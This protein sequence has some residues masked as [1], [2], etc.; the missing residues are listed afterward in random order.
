[1]NQIRKRADAEI[2]RLDEVWDRF[3]NL[4]VQDLEG[5]EILYREMR[6]RFGMYFQGGMGAAALQTRLE[7]FDLEAE[8]ESLREIIRT[9]KGQKKTRALKRLKVVSAFLNTRNSPDGHG[10]RLRPGHP[11]GP[12]PDGAARRWPVRDLATSTTCTAGSST[13]TTASS[14]C[15][16]SARP[17]S[18]ST[19]RSGCCRRPS[20]RCSTTAAAAV[21]SPV[22][23]TAR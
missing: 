23:A 3:R 16:T 9:G 21:R 17:R 4:K 1:M 2:E 7:S 22:R 5:D 20:T 14:G 15:S 18:S 8:A 12:A 11:A 13:A 19:T 10:P 6:D